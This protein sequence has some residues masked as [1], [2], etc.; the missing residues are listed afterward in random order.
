MSYDKTG[1]PSVNINSKN[2]FIANAPYI[3]SSHRNN[4]GDYAA[5][6]N[7]VSSKVLSQKTLLNKYQSPQIKINNQSV[8]KMAKK[9]ET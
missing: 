7:H 5:I 3:P 4:G 9:M 1:M 8:D 2:E 6:P